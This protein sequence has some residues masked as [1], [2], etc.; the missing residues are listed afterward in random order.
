MKLNQLY[1]WYQLLCALLHRQNKGS[2]LS[3]L[4]LFFYWITEKHFFRDFF[5][6]V[7]T[8]W[9]IQ[10]SDRHSTFQASEIHMFWCDFESF[11]SLFWKENKGLKLWYRSKQT[12]KWINANFKNTPFNDSE[13]LFYCLSIYISVFEI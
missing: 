4:S 13:V 12:M 5:I 3:L 6:K 10:I 8:F 11:K 9:D 7:Q 1:S 2:R